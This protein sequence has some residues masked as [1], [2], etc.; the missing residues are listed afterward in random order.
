MNSRLLAVACVAMVSG[1]SGCATARVIKSDPTTV[2]VAV[3]DQTN[4]WPFHYRDEAMKVA[5][6]HIKDPV[7]VGTNRVKVG[8]TVTNTQNTDRR[9]LGGK[10]N[11]PKFGEITSAT[12]T[13]SLRDEYEYHLEFQ[14]RPGG[15]L[16][17]PPMPSGQPFNPSANIRQ[18]GGS[19][20]PP[21]PAL[22]T[23]PRR[24]NVD[25]RIPPAVNPPGYTSPTGFPAVGLPNR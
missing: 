12:S 2:V 3:P 11:K 5:G 6:Q 17:Q 15:S 21:P 16:S 22:G 13:T 1:L 19:Q 24:D 25:P 14:S 8:E 9:D 7:L 18:T 10:D 20:P 4:D 23:A